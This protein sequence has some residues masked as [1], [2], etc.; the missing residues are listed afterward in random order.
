MAFKVIAVVWVIAAIVVVMNSFLCNSNSKSSLFNATCLLVVYMHIHV[1][2]FFSFWPNYFKNIVVYDTC[3]FPD[4]SLVS[5]GEH[6]LLIHSSTNGA[7]VILLVDE[8]GSMNNEYQWIPEMAINLDNLLKENNIGITSANL[9]SVVGFGST[10]FNNRASRILQYNGEV[11]VTSSLVKELTKNLFIG[12]K[13][14]DGYAAVQHA[15]D[16]IPFRGGAKQ[17]ILISDE[18]RDALQPSLNQ[19]HVLSL[20][21]NENAV[22]NVAVSQSF[23]N[24]LGQRALGIDNANRSFVY[25]PFDTLSI[26]ANGKPVEN[27]GH[28]T[29]EF[30]YTYLAFATGGAA[31]DLNLLRNGGEITKIF[32]N[33]FVLVKANEI[34][35][36]NAQC[37]NCS[38]HEFHGTQCV[39]LTLDKCNF[40]GGK[41]FKLNSR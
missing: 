26:Y 34:Y 13:M 25:N 28:G 30:D 33:L 9:F 27:S 38:C 17:F 4:G 24:H 35:R 5:V 20:L 21:M 31:W 12:G 40:T 14:E 39:T 32:T 2:T 16:D 29:T 1:N 11:L 8:S 10:Y 23:Q 7:D 15:L 6:K 3:D 18:N 41:T 37:L 19:S 22:L 36:Q